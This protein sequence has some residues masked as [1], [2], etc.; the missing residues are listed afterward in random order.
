[1]INRA[2]FVDLK[3]MVSS[4][5]ATKRMRRRPLRPAFEDIAELL[6]N[7]HVWFLRSVVGRSIGCA[8]RSLQLDHIQ[9]HLLDRRLEAPV[10][11]FRTHEVRLP[12]F[13]I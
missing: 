1:M 4:L 5:A 3:D 8:R 7:L 11:V 12:G 2:Y 9:R 13:K 6:H 10:V